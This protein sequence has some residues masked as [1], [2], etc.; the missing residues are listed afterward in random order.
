[1]TTDEKLAELDGGSK[2]ARTSSF[3]LIQEGLQ[4]SP[5]KP[6]LIVAH[7]PAEHLSGLLD[8]NDDDVKQTRSNGDST[9]TCFTWTYTQLHHASLKLVN[10][11]FA[12]NIRPKM[13]IVTLIPNSAEWA[14]ILW[15]SVFFR[16]TLSSVD[17]GALSQPRRDE[18]VNFLVTLTPD[19]IVVP[20]AEGAK[21]VD[22][23]LQ[24][25]NT[26]LPLLR[27]TLADSASETWK[28]LVDVATA[29]I[30][31][32][33]DEEGLT[34][35]ALTDDPDRTSLIL[36]TSGT[37]SGKPKGCPRSVR[38]TAFATEFAFLGPRDN[39]TTRA[40]ISS[41]NFR[42]IAPMRMLS[43]WSHGGVNVVINV[44]SAPNILD[45]AEQHR[46]THLIL[47]PAVVHAVAADPKLQ[48]RDLSSVT[49][50]GS[51]GDIITKS[52]LHK[53]KATFPTAINYIGHGMTEGGCIVRWSWAQTPLEQLPYFGEIAPLGRIAVGAKV[54]V[55]NTEERRVAKRGEPG[56]LHLCSPGMITHYLG[57]TNKD[58]FIT[59][60][61]GTP[62][63]NTGDLGMI[64]DDGNVFILGRIKDVMKR[65]AIPITPA[66]LESCI[67]TLTG[68]QVSVPI[69]SHMKSR[70]LTP[71]R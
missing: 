40:L 3:S 31:Q 51:G 28:S 70:E 25:A 49:C 29:D 32:Q 50:V 47:F 35:A 46:I 62:W 10:G 22:E 24:A 43:T 11:M 58:A 30:P 12:C 48:Q 55:W 7:Q 45:A 6:A 20:D 27:L 1:M 68:E 36:F 18:L 13:T 2:E 56:E 5:D 53:M 23:A 42:I 41:A 57:H 9:K 15:T 69:T 59:G 44:A 14:L 4:K 33:I 60:D 38:V 21:A 52:L 39:T 61:D 67:V 34:R 65:A 8:S 54:R 64:D 37:S 26:I 71:S 16:T 66:A 19:V 17:P 63:F